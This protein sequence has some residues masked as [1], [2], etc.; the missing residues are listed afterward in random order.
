MNKLRNAIAVAAVSLTTPALAD[1]VR[2]DVDFQWYT[3]VGRYD[4]PPT[5]VAQPAPRAGYIWTPERWETSGE[6]QKHIAAHW[7]VD[8]YY[9]Q[10]AI[11]NHPAVVADAR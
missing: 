7:V 2:P 10:L 1:S 3:N 5:P 11:Y 8:D 6:H 4:A 9:A